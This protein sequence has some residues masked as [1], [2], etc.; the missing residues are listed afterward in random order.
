MIVWKP[1]HTYR[2]QIRGFA[3]QQPRKQIHGEKPVSPPL[4]VQERQKNTTPKQNSSS[5][6]AASYTRLQLRDGR[7]FASS[8]R[9]FQLI[10]N[11]QSL[12]CLSS[13]LQPAPSKC[14]YSVSAAAE[15]PSS[16]STRWSW[17]MCFLTLTQ[18]CQCWDRALFVTVNSI[19]RQL[20]PEEPPV[21]HTQVQRGKLHSSFCHFHDNFH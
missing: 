10:P 19:Y 17:Q 5:Q 8:H 21:N 1:P 16:G 13:R 18:R 2:L 15:P 9:C 14:I 3:F 4:R 20:C 11:S 6:R 7:Y 12:P